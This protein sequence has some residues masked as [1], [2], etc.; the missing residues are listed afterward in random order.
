[1]SCIK[2]TVVVMFSAVI[3]TSVSGRVIALKP[4]GVPAWQVRFKSSTHCNH[5]SKCYWLLI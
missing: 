3:C 1:M 2:F 4:N 5:A